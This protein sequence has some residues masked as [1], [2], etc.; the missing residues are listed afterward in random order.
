MED[1]KRHKLPYTVHISAELA[2]IG[3]KTQLA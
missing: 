1:V 3:G 2:Q